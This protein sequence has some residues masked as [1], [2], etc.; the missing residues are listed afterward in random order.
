VVLVDAT[1]PGV[2]TVMTDDV[3]GGRIATRHLVELGHRDIAFIGDHADNGFGFTSSSLREQGYTEV[4]R[5]T[6]R[7]VRRAYIR[8]CPHQRDEAGHATDQ[9]LS[10]REPPTA[11]FAASDVQATG[12]VEAA[13]ARGVRIPN[14]L[15][16]VGFDDI[17]ISA[18]AGI[19]TV[20]QPLFESGHFGARL[21]LDALRSGTRPAATEHKLP[22]ELVPRSTTAPPPR[23]RVRG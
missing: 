7:K 17:E 18:Y 14:D 4:L 13:R 23:G 19:T 10:L 5:S 1:G 15:S 3:E 6:G 9:L 2:P 21:L 16:V 8:H 12:V 20:H 22:L 11:V